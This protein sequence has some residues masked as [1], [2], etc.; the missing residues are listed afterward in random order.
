[1]TSDKVSEDECNHGGSSADPPLRQLPVALLKEF[2]R[3]H[4]GI[5]QQIDAR[6][7][8]VAKALSRLG[9]LECLSPDSD[10]LSEDTWYAISNSRK[11]KRSHGESSCAVNHLRQLVGLPPMNR[12]TK[13]GTG[14]TNAAI[15]PQSSTKHRRGAVV[16]A[17]AH[18]V[19]GGDLFCACVDDT[20][21][22]Y[23][24]ETQEWL[25]VGM[26]R[27]VVSMACADR[28]LYALD[29]EA[30]VWQM[31]LHVA[32]PD[33]VIQEAFPAGRMVALTT[34]AGCLYGAT[35]DGQ[36]IKKR[37]EAAGDSDGDLPTSPHQW[38]VVGRCQDPVALAS[39]QSTLYAC[40]ADRSLWSLDL[41]PAAAAGSPVWEA[42]G[43]CSR[44]WDDA[45]RAPFV[46][47]QDFVAFGGRLHAV[48]LHHILSKPLATVDG[49]WEPFS[50][51]PCLRKPCG[52][53][54]VVQHRETKIEIVWMADCDSCNRWRRV[55]PDFGKAVEAGGVFKC[56]D[57]NRSCSEPDDSDGDGPLELAP[58]TST[59][60]T[61]REDASVSG[62]PHREQG[63]QPL[64]TSGP[65]APPKSSAAVT[66]TECSICQ[67]IPEMDAIV[68]Q[69]PCRHQF[70]HHCIEQW[71]ETHAG[72][73]LAIGTPGTAIGCH[74]MT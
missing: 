34:C 74:T 1:M 13:R 24:V 47:T 69:L 50:D 5:Q 37:L 58:P 8:Y 71:W 17:L 52:A 4:P 18:E 40:C 30:R 15:R 72:M 7:P 60:G 28:N 70:C 19:H 21:W 62:A 31:N 9:E 45:G 22:K 59:A 11:D 51:L 65:A 49:A 66:A 10:L 16:T 33:W 44:Q 64:E 26:A 61:A 53:Q 6:P 42:D 67:E 57:A 56:S 12:L 41:D 14:Q 73:P 38:V 63:S 55:S 2:L 23:A 68:C 46:L 20:L 39:A 54:P 35:A 48:D 29:S 3:N 25:H 27:K 36:L 43:T 32:T